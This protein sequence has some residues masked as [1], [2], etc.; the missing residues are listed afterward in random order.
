MGAPGQEESC[1][2]GSPLHR[3][4]PILSPFP[5]LLQGDN[6]R[7]GPR[8]LQTMVSL[9]TGSLATSLSGTSLGKAMPLR[10]FS[11][12]FLACLSA[13]RAQ[14]KRQRVG[15]L[16]PALGGMQGSACSQG[17][18]GPTEEPLVLL[19]WALLLALAG[20][21][22]IY[23]LFAKEPGAATGRAWPLAPI[24]SW[25][26]DR[27]LLSLFGDTP[28][29]EDAGADPDAQLEETLLRDVSGVLHI[30]RLRLWKIVRDRRKHQQLLHE[31]H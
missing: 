13:S 22:V 18:G 25:L 28:E 31:S 16:E 5:C 11:L 20:S 26:K 10:R 2:C 4:P 21:L 6:G 3:T 24:S 19:P 29:A 8:K 27:S 15:E 1:S 12:L 7:V 30:I 14:L 17:D 9:A 23:L